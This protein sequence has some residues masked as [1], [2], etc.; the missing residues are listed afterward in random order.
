[1]RLLC[2]EVPSPKPPQIAHC[3]EGLAECKRFADTAIIVTC[4]DKGK[5]LYRPLM[6]STARPA[7]IR[8]GLKLHYGD[9]CQEDADEP[10]YA[11]HA[12]WANVAAELMTIAAQTGSDTVWVDS[13]TVLKP[14]YR[15]EMTIDLK[16]LYAAMAPLRESG[17]D[18]ML[19]HPFVVG[20]Q[21]GNPNRCE[22]SIELVEVVA[23]A[24]PRAVF[25][26][27]YSGVFGWENTE[28][29]DLRRHMVKRVGAQRIIELQ[30]PQTTFPNGDSAYTPREAIESEWQLYGD[31]HV[32]YPSADKWVSACRAYAALLEARSG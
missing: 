10:N 25:V 8:P 15:G 14:F 23:V 31:A 22:R 9:F 5:W 11:D 29:A 28:D 21:E 3:L 24:V 4:A 7:C 17:L 16:M 1:M 12:F 27:S 13:E 18:V 6:E 30:Y 20:D 26:P 32:I 2:L 19:R